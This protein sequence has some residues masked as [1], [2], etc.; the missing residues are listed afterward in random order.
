M[1]ADERDGTIGVVL[2]DD[3]P[4]LRELTRYGLEQDLRLRV[5]GEAG[6]ADECFTIVDRLSPD[7]LLLDLTL[8][9]MDGLE[10]IPRL[11][12]LAPQL[13]IIV[14]SGMDA[15]RME[16]RALARGAD[17]YVEKGT[18]L[19]EIRKAVLRAARGRGREVGPNIPLEL[20]AS[21]APVA[22]TTRV[23]PDE[24][25]ETLDELERFLQLLEQRSA[26]L[27]GEDARRYLHGAHDALDTLR[28]RLGE[29]L[30]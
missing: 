29:R 25:S 6:S 27:L 1:T 8:P 2:C 17:A 5:L 20:R 13:S 18:S 19:S 9:D 30:H 14:F 28:R 3:M 12:E 10:A 22:T 24:V 15:A 4:D 26:A 21:D 7:A 23:L 11:R 16:G